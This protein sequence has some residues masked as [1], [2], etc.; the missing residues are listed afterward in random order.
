MDVLAR[1]AHALRSAGCK[2]VVT[3][4]DEKVRDQLVVTGAA[5]ALGQENIYESDE[6]LGATVR[7]ANDDARTW[8]AANRN[9]D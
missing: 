5:A 4:A 1:Y 9:V 6:W 2:L 3:Y 8:I 7:R